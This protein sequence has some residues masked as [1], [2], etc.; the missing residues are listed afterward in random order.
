MQMNGKM[1]KV[2]AVGVAAL[3]VKV[4][5]FE[6]FRSRPDEV[7][8]ARNRP[9]VLARRAY[10]LDRL[11]GDFQSQA[12]TPGSNMIRGE[13]A[14]GTLSMTAAAL[15]NIGFA[16][17]DTRADSLEHLPGLITRAMTPPIREFDRISWGEDPLASLEG[18]HGHVGY[19]GHLNLMIGAYRILGGDG[20]FNALHSRITGALARRM[21][22]SLSAHIATYPGQVF[23][24]D[25]AVGAA[26]IAVYD[27]VTGEDHRRTLRR[28]IDY[29]RAHLLDPST[30]L[31]V[32]NVDGSGGPAGGARGCAAGW[33]SFYLPMVDEEF[34]REQF[35][36]I[37]RHMVQRTFF[38]TVGI[39]EYPPG[40]QGP[41]DVDSGPVLFGLSPSGTGF[42]IAGAKMWGD[43]ELLGQ[44]L[45]TAEL[46]GFS[47]QVRGERRY[48]TA[49]LVGD[50]IL[51]AMVTACSW[52]T[53][54]VRGAEQP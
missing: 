19:L 24:A 9:D 42:A 29:T 27:R 23:T 30:G 48:L 50:A 20:R 47:V 40:E 33:S 18:P 54:Y 8:E 52:D 22:A 4:G 12:V 51:L 26:S 32:F 15:C 21:D 16:L 39:R 6:Q 28:W 7:L 43:A 31:V 11:R 53:R 5:W 34:A 2:L 49:P 17:P 44:L 14:L 38:G 45:N 10:L 41:G 37:K 35:G 36:A 3:A 13:W 46:A 1:L 25:N